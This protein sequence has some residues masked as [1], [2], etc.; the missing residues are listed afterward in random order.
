MHTMADTDWLEQERRHAPGVYPARDRVFV[1]GAG[2]LLFDA[3]GRR[4]V[5]CAAGQGVAALGHAHPRFVA[6]VAK[7]A[8]M[9][10]TCS[11]GWPTATRAELGVRLAALLPLPDARL[12]WC[13]SGTEAVEAALKF[14]RLATKRTGFV[15]LERGFHGRTFGALSA[16]F[17]A[18]YKTPF[19]PLVPGFSHVPPGDLAA[20][21]AALDERTA[22]LI[23]EVVQGEGG[24]HPLPGDYLRAAAE[25]A[26]ARGV[27][28][29]VDEIQTGYG[30]T[31]RMF[32][33]DHH[34]LEPD[35]LCLGKAIGGGVPMAAV[36]IGPRVAELP[37][38]AHGSTFGGNPLACAAGLAVLDAFEH[39]GLVERAARNGA[40]LAERLRALDAP[41]VREVRGLGLMLALD[42]GEPAAPYVARLV[43]EGV[44]AL[45]AGGTGIRLLPPLVIERAELE[46]VLS[47]L[48]R[49]LAA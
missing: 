39:D 4:Y 49:V 43:D 12:F 35:L 34:G 9:L 17:N 25:L 32:A 40:W 22:G 41:R 14:A 42:V 8:A 46:E 44:I 37:V 31:G 24:V 21:D 48:A 13:N 20:L 2:A 5:D 33:C 1:R 15:A 19:E 16:T 38:G 11:A 26:R 6:A 18:S 10:T 29:I 45:P 23:L 3:E 28:V 36:A 27:L 7:Q 47:A 30:R